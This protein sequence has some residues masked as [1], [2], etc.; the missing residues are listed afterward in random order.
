L[1]PTSAVGAVR[2]RFAEKSAY[3]EDGQVGQPV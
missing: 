1:W 3:T 2:R